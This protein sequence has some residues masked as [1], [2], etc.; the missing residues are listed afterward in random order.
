MLNRNN[1]S[2]Q[3]SCGTF[4]KEAAKFCHACG[5]KVVKD[6]NCKVCANKIDETDIF[7]SHCGTKYD[8]NS[9]EIQDED[10]HHEMDNMQWYKQYFGYV[11]DFK[12][13]FAPVIDNLTNPQYVGFVTSGIP[14]K[15]QAVDLSSKLNVP[16]YILLHYKINKVIFENHGEDRIV[17][18]GEFREG[19]AMIANSKGELFT[20]DREGHIEESVKGTIRSIDGFSPTQGVIVSTCGLNEQLQKNH[21]YDCIID[22]KGKLVRNEYEFIHDLS[23]STVLAVNIN[24]NDNTLNKQGLVNKFN[25]KQ[26]VPAKYSSL[27][28]ERL[29]MSDGTAKVFIKTQINNA[30]GDFYGFL[31]TEKGWVFKTKYC[32]IEVIYQSESVKRLLICLSEQEDEEETVYQ[33]AVSDFHGNI[34]LEYSTTDR[35]LSKIEEDVCVHIRNKDG[36]NLV[37]MDN[38]VIQSFPNDRQ[39]TYLG[40]GY[41]KVINQNGHVGVVDRRGQV[42]IP[43]G[44]FDKINSYQL[45]DGAIKVTKNNL[46]GF[47]D[48][49]GEIL[50]PLMY[51]DIRDEYSLDEHPRI[52]VYPVNGSWFYINYLN[53]TDGNV[54]AE[55]YIAQKERE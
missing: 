3:C 23:Y 5:S 31:D 27:D 7:C 41:F 12:D 17:W 43:F 13:G 21:N 4:L 1:E 22:F 36:I 46:V 42:S 18:A 55:Q 15:L 44:L 49:K 48:A 32:S 25:G 30:R 19:K 34:L 26:V 39:V 20:V 11:G 38:R 6:K 24:L 47:V 54:P 52:L 51:K 14:E 10:S 35:S 40:E 33:M 37:G 28:E 45:N 53:R 50:I 2:V 8:G 9:L 29:V 16:S